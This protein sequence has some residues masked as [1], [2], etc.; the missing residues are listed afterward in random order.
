MASNFGVVAYIKP[1]TLHGVTQPDL[2]KFETEYTAYKEKLQNV[3]N[4]REDGNKLPTATIR[5][6][7]DGP[8]L[9]AL[10]IMGK[11]SG[12]QT[13][14]QATPEKVEDWFTAAHTAAP[15][16][17]SERIHSALSAVK[18]KDCQAD[19]AGAALT[20]CLDA[21]KA[22]DKN[23]AS[24]IMQDQH[25]AAYLI[26]KLEEK[27][28]PD[29][30]RERVKMRRSTW[31]KADKGDILKFQECISALAVDVS[32]NEVARAR[33][34]GG[35]KRSN[36]ETERQ[37]SSQNKKKKGKEP[38]T[39]DTDKQ[40][41]SSSDGKGKRTAKKSK[42]WT[43]KCLNPECTETH[44]LKDCDNTAE[45]LKKKLL[46][47]YYEKQKSKKTKAL[48]RNGQ[49]FSGSP[50]NGRYQVTIEDTVPAIALGDYGSDESVL[51][52]KLMKEITTAD[53]SVKI[54]TLPEPVQL[55][56][57]D[58]K[59]HVAVVKT[60]RLTIVLY[61][62]G[63][64]IPV[65]FRDIQ[66]YV[67][68]CEM[69]EI[70]LGRPFLNSIGF[71]LDRHLEKLG[72]HENPEDDS[73]ES[74]SVGKL[75]LPVKI[76]SV[77]YSGLSY[78]STND[79][80]IEL[81]ENMA[82]KIGTDSKESIDSAFEGMLQTATKNGVSAKGRKRLEGL[83]QTYRDIFRIKLG[84]DEP[85]RVEPL[86]IECVAG[87]RPF[88]T[89][90]RRYAPLQTAFINKTIKDLE[91]VGAVRRNPTAK[92]ASPALAVPKPGSSE[93][94]FTVDLRGVNAR[95]VPVQSAMPH[96]ESK[97]QETAGSRVYAKLDAPHS[98]WQLPLAQSSQ[99]MMSIQT[100]AG[101]F[102]PDRLLQGGSDSGN[103]LQA[104]LQHRFSSIKKLLQWID[105]FLLHAQT[106]VELIDILEEFF[107]ICKAI[108][109]KMHAKKTTLFCKEVTFCGRI[110]SADGIRH[111]PRHF[112]SLVS[113]KRPKMAHELQQLLCATIWMRTSLPNYAAVIA[114]LHDL[115]EQVYAK[116]GKRT[117]TAIRKQTLDNLWGREHDE[118]FHNIKQ[119]LAAAVKLA[120][121]KENYLIC[122]FTDASESH[123]AAILTQV[124][125]DQRKRDIEEQEH[126]PLCFLSG[127]F[128]N[129]SS[130]WSVPEKEGFAI[131][132]SM[133]RLDHIVMGRQVNIF[134]DHANLVYLYDPHGKNPG[135]P[136]HTATKL[137][138]WALK[139]SAYR[140]VVEHLAGE[141]NVWADMLTRWAV[142]TADTVKAKS[143]AA[144]A[145]MLSPIQPGTDKA[146]DMPTGKDL[147]DAQKKSK[148]KPPEECNKVDGLW[149]TS[150][151]AVWIPEQD[152]LMKL[153][154][155]IA[156]HAGPA[157]HR[158]QAVS[159]ANMTSR[160]VWKGMR[161]DTQSFVNS[162][163]H[164][165]C[166][167]TPSVVPRP[168]GTAIHAEK[169]NE[170]LHFDY[171]YMTPSEGNFLYILI[172]KDDHSGYIRLVPTQAANAEN[173]ARAL[174]DWFTTF[175]V[176]TQ[177]V[178]DRGSH[179]R[180]EL[181]T[182][183]Q[184]KLRVSHHFTLAYCPWSNGTVEVV[185]REVLRACRALLSE[186][187][188]PQKSWPDVVPMIQSA[189]NNSILAR[190][191][192]RCP[193]TVFTGLKQSSPISTIIRRQVG[194]VKV[195]SLDEVRTRQRLKVQSI[196]N[197]LEEMHKDVAGRKSKSRQRAIESFNR[198]VGV[199][200]VNFTEGD[201]VLRGVMERERA[202]KPAL[203]W[204]GPY[205][206]VRC[207][208]DYIFVIEHLITGNKQQAHGRRLKFFRNST[209]EVSEDLKE[210]LEYQD[211]EMLVV[212][213][214]DDIR[215][216]NGVPEVQVTWKGFGPEET[217]WV[218][219]ESMR[220]DVPELLK[221]ALESFAETGT[222]RQRAVVNTI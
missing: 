192:N 208:S 145:L 12:A 44:K 174:V 111:H 75:A 131:V 20:F 61:L 83:L 151:G 30:L 34:S 16:D 53:P 117:K 39:A 144:K 85:A 204:K 100:P 148:T 21:I 132:E 89:P 218:N 95:T 88:K 38:H 153:R 134:T 201:F 143:V 97:L 15:R 103:H 14:E 41:G 123:W 155:L 28:Q 176:V 212:D 146:F 74:D 32:Q 60:T 214:I 23:N 161:E 104:E 72:E 17:L 177:L 135:M 35:K 57:A 128:R 4:G 125:S 49:E 147:R 107:R 37:N 79:D 102:T 216:H 5:D 48:K 157:G 10:C 199:R 154:V 92:W 98:F 189:L 73:S 121:V 222:A 209:F 217:D 81:P 77:G 108:N 62:P 112:E 190:L 213:R 71:N 219:L 158:G 184:A 68:E 63:S 137:M 99:E 106:E 130:N 64:N 52:S 220:E 90:Q 65:R 70:L 200:P 162:C 47:E 149:Q 27:L 118:A 19:P 141:R 31:T 109:L 87:A 86:K 179:F 120:H 43:A 84:V 115:L 210:H 136:R 133:T 195:H 22:L 9:Q 78:L 165:E 171:L 203:R 46:D 194:A 150:K 183:L 55:E 142:R 59:V 33:L 8:T 3:N 101:V 69:D 7:I 182:M 166:S 40:H 206:V 170:L 175:G 159:L 198:K 6:C 191:G 122:L 42:G 93:L 91:R 82:A 2:I 152:S 94:R 180:N 29:L 56:L 25:K 58:K 140:Y 113:M 202:K 129:A 105:D 67:A 197:A 66:F 138:R 116:T 126:E 1:P 205:R 110:I 207:L 193:L 26:N 173:A 168:L 164:C 114:P 163:L 11:I 221:E 156:A 54:D 76:A 215:L 24:E 13:M 167:K 96:L 172:L 181:V 80:P 119:Q 139:L 187:Q 196:Q 169:P 211:G 51:P 186:L 127:S 160:F 45:D 50:G 18:Y 178:S 185:C 124:P 188:L 36:T